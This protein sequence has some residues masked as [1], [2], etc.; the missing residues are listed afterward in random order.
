MVSLS[1]SS[2]TGTTQAAIPEIPINCYKVLSLQSTLQSSKFGFR[3]ARPLQRF[4]SN[5]TTA[6]LSSGNDLGTGGPNPHSAEAAP[7]RDPTNNIHE[8]QHNDHEDRNSQFI[9]RH[10]RM[11]CNTCSKKLFRNNER[12]GIEKCEHT[13]CESHFTSANISFTVSLS[14]SLPVMEPQQS[15]VE[16]AH[17]HKAQ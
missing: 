2:K 8:L 11:M 3:Q 9:N 4:A 1:K 16:R 5:N 10:V 12:Q 17:G 13:S 15:S 6:Y 7:M 14:L